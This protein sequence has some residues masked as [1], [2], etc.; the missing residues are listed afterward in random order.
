MIVAK[1]RQQSVAPMIMSP[2]FIVSFIGR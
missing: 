1:E 2:S